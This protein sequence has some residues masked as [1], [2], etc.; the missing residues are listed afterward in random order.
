MGKGEVARESVLEFLLAG[1][2]RTTLKSEKTGNQ[3]TYKILLNDKDNEKIKNGVKVNPIMY[4]VQIA[5]EYDKYTY[6]GYILVDSEKRTVTFHQGKKG[7]MIE[8]STS[9]KGLVWVINR[10]LNDKSI[11]GVQVYH[12]GKCAKCGRALTDSDSIRYGLGPVC[13][14]GKFKKVI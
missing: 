7:K 13:R 12:L 10:L 14:R 4:Y 2:C 8:T 1:R 9:I 11:D 5:Y 3:Y 6:A